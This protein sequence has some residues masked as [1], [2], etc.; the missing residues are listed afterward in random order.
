[1][2]ALIFL[3]RPY[4][5]VPAGSAQQVS[6]RQGRNDEHISFPPISIGLGDNRSRR[7]KSGLKLWPR[8]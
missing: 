5:L 8:I 6:I 7:K 1:M 3:T 4:I 2:R